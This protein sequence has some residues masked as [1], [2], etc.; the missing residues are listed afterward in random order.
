MIH[1]F[2]KGGQHNETFANYFSNL[3]KAMK[4]K[5]PEKKLVYIMDNL[6]AH[7]S[8]LVMRIM[9]E[10]KKYTSV[11]THWKYV[12]PKQETHEGLLT[13]EE[14]GHSFPHHEWNVWIKPEI[15]LG[16]FQEDAPEYALLLVQA[17]LVTA[18]PEDQ[19]EPRSKWV[20]LL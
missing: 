13:Q 15:Y 1:F 20:M 16:I 11:F 12:C 18:Q 6:W 3:M 8:S 17:G 7:K 4:E 2:Y 14:R 10:D 5:Y 19:K 9:Q